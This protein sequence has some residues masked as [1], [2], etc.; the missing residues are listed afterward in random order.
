MMF[1]ETQS[2]KCLGLRF[3]KNSNKMNTN[4]QLFLKII[5]KS[6]KIILKKQNINTDNLVLP[7][8]NNLFCYFLNKNIKTT[9]I[10]SAQ[11]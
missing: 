3:L 5:F 6:K 4:Y 7:F 11:K 9:L 8:N 2:L 1:N 10:K